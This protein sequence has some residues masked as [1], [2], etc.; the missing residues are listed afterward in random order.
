MVASTDMSHYPVQTE[1]SR[2]DHA[3]LKV[4]A[5]FNPDEVYAADER[6]LGENVPNLHCTLC[7]LGPLVAVMKAAQKLGAD[8]AQVLKYA[9]SA[10]AEP[11]TARRCV[12]YG[13]VVFVGKRISVSSEPT[14]E[15]NG[16]EDIELTQEQREWL[17]ELARRTIEQYVSSHQ[18][19]EID[20][21]DPAMH[22][23]RAVF[24]TLT[25]QSRL[26]GCIGQIKARMA[27]AEAVR[28]A[29]ISA[30]TR[31]PRFPAVRPEELDKIHIEISV[32]SPLRQVDN[33]NEIEVGKHGVLVRQGTRQGVF[34]PQVAPEQG[35]NREQ[36][37]THLCADKAGLPPDAWRKTATLYVF[38]AQIFGAED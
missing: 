33:A 23:Q 26:R 21:D 12:G 3:M 1:A 2:V 18:L 24:V 22:E 6:L 25:K 20:T 37:L 34:L 15:A 7:G 14:A 29:A 5:A 16:E 11:A 17:L 30:A 32:L 9:N 35:W 10:D 4:I 13:A 8:R 36:M 38:T 28:D 31:D 27:L 19:A